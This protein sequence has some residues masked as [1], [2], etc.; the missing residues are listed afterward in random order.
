MNYEEVNELIKSKPALMLYFSGQ[1]CG[2]CEVLHPKIERAFQDEFPLIEQV[3]IVV[4]Q[5]PKIAAQFNVFSMPTI[6]IYFEGKEF[7]RKARNLSVSGFVQEV[8]RP[9]GLYFDNGVET[10]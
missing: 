4:E 3:S 9:Y 8:K 6:I 7:L 10:Q 5:N 1:F 2:V